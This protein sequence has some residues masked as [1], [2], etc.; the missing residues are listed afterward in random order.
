MMIINDNHNDN[1]NNN[2][3]C[4]YNDKNKKGDTIFLLDD[5]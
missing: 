5:E 4:N 2:Y 1:S 3:N